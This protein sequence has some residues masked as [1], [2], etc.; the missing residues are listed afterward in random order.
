M[1]RL[2]MVI[3]S[4]MLM[5][6]VSGCGTLNLQNEGQASEIEVIHFATNVGLKPEDGFENWVQE[7]TNQT[8]VDLEFDYTDT[9]EYYSD[10]EVGFVSG[11]VPDVFMV[12]GDR[13]PMYALNDDL[14]DLT[15]L[16][17]NSE[18]VKNIES[19]LIDSIK[20]NGKIFGVPLERGG[21]AITY[22]RKDWLNQLG[23]DEPTNY[24]EFIEVLRAFKTLGDD[25]IPFTAPGFVADHAEYY[26]GQF[27]QDATPNFVLNESGEWVDGMLQANI[28][29]ALERLKSAYAEG[30][31]DPEIMT[32]KT[33]TCR[34]K[35]YLGNVGV[36]NYWAGNWA[37][38]LEDR[39][40]RNVNTAEVVA[41]PPI[42]ES[43][44]IERLANVISISS[45][46]KQPEEVFKYFIEYAADRGKGSMLFQHGVENRH[47][48]VDESGKVIAN[49]KQNKKD[50][51]YEKAFISPVLTTT[52][53]QLEGYSFRVDERVERSLDIFYD[54]CTKSTIMPDS[55]YL[56]QISSEVI[57]L[58]ER[59][60][61]Q[62]IADQISIEEGI[63][64][65]RKQAAAIGVQEAL[66][67]LNKNK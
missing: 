42:S 16:V 58:K 46:C 35:W 63:K 44:Y 10:L 17:Q 37:V 8:G 56:S 28:I 12:S 43:C 55:E 25:V 33:S 47:Y 50:E 26:L 1:Q 13:L 39:L 51:V 62:I 29:P 21:G 31:I 18:Y 2:K 22:I 34:N 27:Y 3:M 57:E 6:M 4:M 9:N 61:I 45:K 53:I 7:Y 60:I 64:Q 11:N 48:K 36:F 66:K 38:S 65:Y 23:L 30:L 67:E 15:D 20:V 49:V 19:E 59:T 40:K 32:N 52:P 14:Y 54:N 41:I 24:E 5:G